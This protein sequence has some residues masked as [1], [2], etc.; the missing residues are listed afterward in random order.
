MSLIQPSPSAGKFNHG[1][2]VSSSLIVAAGHGTE[3]FNVVE[4]AFDSIAF[5][6]ESA[7][8]APSI[9]L[10]GGIAADDDLH[11]APSNLPR[12]IVGVVARVTDKSMALRVLEQLVGCDHVMAISRRQRDVERTTFEVGERVDLRRESSSTTTQT[13]ADDPPF[14][15]AASW[16]ARTLLPSTMDPVLSTLT[17]SALKIRVK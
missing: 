10:S 17:R 1:E 8:E 12:Q 6:I 3:P 11:F 5:S 9:F 13:I 15:P 16:C 2:E 14:P 7:V 4:E